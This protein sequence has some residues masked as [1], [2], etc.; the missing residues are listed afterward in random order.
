MLSVVALDI[1]DGE[2][3]RTAAKRHK[4]VAIDVLINSAGIAGSSG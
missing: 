2:S 1:T 4:D 3:V